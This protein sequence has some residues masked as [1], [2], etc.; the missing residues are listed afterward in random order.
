MS[1]KVKIIVLAMVMGFMTAFAVSGL[2]VYNTVRMKGAILAKYHDDLLAERQNMLEEMTRI[3]WGTFDSI[4]SDSEDF[5]MVEQGQVKDIFKNI[6]YGE[7][8]D[9]YFWINDLGPTMV[10]HPINPTLNGKDLSQMKDPHGTYLFNEFV[11]VAKQD[12]A[13][14][15]EYFWPKPGHDE[16]V[17]KISYV[18]LYPKWGW[19]VGTGLYVDD[20]DAA[21]AARNRE[22]N[23]SIKSF[24]L[25]LAGLVALGILFGFILAYGLA[26]SITKQVNVVTGGISDAAAQIAGAANQ[27]AAGSQN[28]ADGASNQAA[29]LEETSSSL[30]EIGSMTRQNADNTKQADSLAQ[31]AEAVVQEGASNMEE[32]LRAVHEI[33]DSSEKTAKI[34]KT[35]DEIAFQTN[36]LSLNAAVEAARAGEAGAGFAV[37]ADEVRNLAH[38]SAEAAKNT[39]ELIDRSVASSVR[40]VELSERVAASFEEINSAIKKVKDL[41]AEVAAASDEQSQGLGQISTVVGQMDKITQENAANAEESAASIMELKSQIDTV[42]GMVTQLVQVLGMGNRGNVSQAKKSGLPKPSAA[43]I[44]MVSARKKTMPVKKSIRQEVSPEDI[45]PLDDNDDQTLSEF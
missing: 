36:L 24:L 18:K 8:G 40:G 42:D 16:P 21:V 26:Q 45:I 17:K 35:I 32:M 12:G 34:I 30:E 28:L 33:R 31:Q 7:N 29:S 11:R 10:M 6:R 43:G 41:V 9:G 22:I 20:I 4:V 38:R 27:I 19:I 15:V 13:G 23:A 44:A 39:T 2:S 37:V 1:L 5:M 3:A 14:F 25:L